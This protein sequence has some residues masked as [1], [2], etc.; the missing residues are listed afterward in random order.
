[1]GVIV[2]FAVSSAEL[3]DSREVLESVLLAIQ[4]RG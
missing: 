2:W 1:M 4:Q 3:R